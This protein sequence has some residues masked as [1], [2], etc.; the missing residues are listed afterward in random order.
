M[1][2]KKL[3]CCPVWF[4]QDRVDAGKP[5]A[6]AVGMYIAVGSTHGL[7]LV[8]GTFTTR[9]YSFLLPLSWLMLDVGRHS[10]LN[11]TQ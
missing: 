6:L 2:S 7:I 8:F 1:K 11:S 5:S 10:H 9:E 4:N 3:F